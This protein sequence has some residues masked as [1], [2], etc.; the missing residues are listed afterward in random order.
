M[1]QP[2][3]RRPMPPKR[4]RPSGPATPPVHNNPPP[5]PRR[6]PRVSDQLVQ[7]TILAMCRAAGPTG[8]VRPEDVARAILEKEWQTLLKRV[9]E[10]A[11][12][13]A[14]A[15]D[16]LIL[17]RGEAADPEDFKGLVKFQITPQGMKKEEEG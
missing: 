7:S 8:T 13:H 4:T 15:G 1:K 14:I 2:T 10:A 11:A 5:K 9:R 3:N 12:K 16:I 6:R 17:R